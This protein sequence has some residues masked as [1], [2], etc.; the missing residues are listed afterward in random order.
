MIRWHLRQDAGDATVGTRFPLGELVVGVDREQGNHAVMGLPLTPVRLQ[1]ALVVGV[2]G[3]DKH[4]QVIALARAGAAEHP[5]V[6]REELTG[7][8]DRAP[9]ATTVH[10]RAG[11]P[12]RR[13][14]PVAWPAGRA[15]TVLLPAM[16]S[17]SPVADPVDLGQMGRQLARRLEHPVITVGI[18]AYPSSEPERRSN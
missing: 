10:R 5:Q 9:R 4:H 16:A 1:Q 2:D 15:S 3:S 18:S 14:S 7:H 12:H 8:I 6:V 11:R 17:S 13:H